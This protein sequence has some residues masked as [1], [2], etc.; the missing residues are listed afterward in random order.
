VAE[1]SA[2][3]AVLEAAIALLV[4]IV[5]AMAPRIVN[6]VYELRNPAQQTQ[7]T[8]EGTPTARGPSK[9]GASL[10]GT[11][12]DSKSGVPIPQTQVMLYFND[13]PVLLHVK[14]GSDGLFRFLDLAPGRYRVQAA[15]VGYQTR[16][17][18]EGDEPSFG[19]EIKVP[20]AELS[21][22]HL[23]NLPTHPRVQ[24]RD[25]VALVEA[26]AAVEA[27]SRS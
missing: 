1:P 14:T 3:R 26:L 19:T 7:T 18:G 15:K 12:R 20:Q 25:A 9:G 4:L 13:G 5:A 21:A 2:R 27:S 17:H 6:R 16:Y 22:S 8:A 23:Y 10:H 24:R 11:V